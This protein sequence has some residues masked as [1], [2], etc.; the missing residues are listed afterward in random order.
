MQLSVSIAM[1]CRSPVLWLPP[2]IG[3]VNGTAYGPGSL[4]SAYVKVTGYLVCVP[5]TVT[6]GMPIGPPLYRPAPKSAC[7]FLVEPMVVTQLEELV[8]TG[9]WSTGVF[10]IL[11][12]G[13]TG[14]LPIVGDWPKA[15]DTAQRMN[16]NRSMKAPRLQKL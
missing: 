6:N 5:G 15:V 1:A 13:W 2:S 10:Q 14:Q 8:E 11:S 16:R 12:A 9:S 4:S 3:A 7:R